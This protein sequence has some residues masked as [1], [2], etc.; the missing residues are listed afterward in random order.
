[1]YLYALMVKTR[2][3]GQV[4]NRA[5]YVAIGITVEGHKEVLSLWTSVQQG[6]EFGLQVLY[7]AS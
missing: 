4:Q 1:M 2:D 5:V 6:A 3:N 7:L